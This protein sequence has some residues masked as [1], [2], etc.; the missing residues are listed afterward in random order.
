[1][2]KANGVCHKFRTLQ[3][4]IRREAARMIEEHTFEVLEMHN[5][6]QAKELR[7]TA[8]GMKRAAA[9]HIGNIDS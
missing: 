5:N 3:E 4:G 2:F 6:S 1:M 7:A 9:S 8:E